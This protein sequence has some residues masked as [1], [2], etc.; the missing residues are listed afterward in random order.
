MALTD[1]DGVFGPGGVGETEP[2]RLTWS[3]ADDRANDD[4]PRD[5]EVDRAVGRLFA[6]RARQEAVQRNRRGDYEVRDTSSMR[7][8]VAFAATRAT[9][10]SF[11]TSSTTRDRAGDLRRPDGRTTS[12]GGPF[13]QREHAPQ[14]RCEGSLGEAVLTTD[15]VVQAD[16]DRLSP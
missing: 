15:R 8:L 7:P 16:S 12:Q 9:I 10:R 11:V 1:R 2:Q 3:Y 14:P 5:A 13:R 4:Q 6:A